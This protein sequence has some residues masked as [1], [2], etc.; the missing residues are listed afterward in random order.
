MKL[1]TCIL[2]GTLLA[3]TQAAKYLH[4]SSNVR[5]DNR[6]KLTDILS[7]IDTN[8]CWIELTNIEYLIVVKGYQRN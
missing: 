7:A 8:V 4:I 5:I 2:S 6:A 3:H 1:V